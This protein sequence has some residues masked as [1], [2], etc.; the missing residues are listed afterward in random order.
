MTHDPIE[1]CLREN[2]RATIEAVYEDE[3]A[4][5]PGRCR[6]DRGTAAFV[7]VAARRFYAAFLIS[8]AL[9]LHSG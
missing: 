2:I 3:M 7:N 6:R 9:I 5:F 4:D 8:D 1:L